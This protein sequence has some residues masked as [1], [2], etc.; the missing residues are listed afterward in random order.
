MSG[1]KEISCH[2]LGSL[3]DGVSYSAPRRL[4]RTRSR[5]M[6]RSEQLAPAEIDQRPTHISVLVKSV[7]L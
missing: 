3:V 7:Q 5:A 4:N 2:A 1:L 6:P